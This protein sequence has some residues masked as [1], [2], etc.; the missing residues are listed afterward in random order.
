MARAWQAT[1]EWLSQFWAD[2]KSSTDAGLLAV[3]RFLG[4][5]YGPIDT[6]LPIDE[7]W[8]KALAHRPGTVL[9]QVPYHLAPA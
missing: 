7:A 6:R 2:V 1:R 8:R 5:L 3:P 4:L 9:V